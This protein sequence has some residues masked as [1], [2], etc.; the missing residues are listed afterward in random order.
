VAGLAFARNH[1]CR[2]V[3][4]API[5]GGTRCHSGDPAFREGVRAPVVESLPPSVPIGRCRAPRVVLGPHAGLGDGAVEH[6]RLDAL[7]MRRR[8]DRRDRAAVPLSD[9]DRPRAAGRVEDRADVVHALLEGRH[10]I[11]RDRVG[12]PDAALV[13]DD[14]PEARSEAVEE[15]DDRRLFAVQVE[16]R[17]PARDVDEVGRRGP[18]HLV[19]DVVLATARVPRR[20]MV[21]RPR[22]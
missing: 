3:D 2:P 12:Q 11:G 5:V 7:G 16:M 10:R 22:S 19:G 4:E 9:D 8:E 6:Q 1:P 13:E 18:E 15:A 20:R 14:Q 17:D 21:H